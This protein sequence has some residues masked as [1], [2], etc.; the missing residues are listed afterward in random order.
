MSHGASTTPPADRRADSPI[1]NFRERNR[2]PPN[3]PWIWLTREIIES[4]AWRALSHSAQKVIFR[5]A[6]EHLAH[7]G[8]LNGQ[9]PVTYRDFQDYG[10]GK[11]SIYEGLSEALELGLIERIDAGHQAWGEFKGRPATYALG[12][13]PLHNGRPALDCWRRF[14]RLDEAKAA[15]AGARKRVATER[16][17][18]RSLRVDMSVQVIRKAANG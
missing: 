14:E 12:W 9:L 11:A 2:P 13:L 6:L 10:V 16:R 5:I 18:S 7:G 15:A 3:E 4:P 8:G 17:R 1:R